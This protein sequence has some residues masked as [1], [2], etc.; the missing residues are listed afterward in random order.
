MKVKLLVFLSSLVLANSLQAQ[1]QDGGFAAG[2][3][4]GTTGLGI[5]AATRLSQSF[6][7]RGSYNFLEYE[8]DFDE[9]DINYDA[10]FNRN[11]LGFLVDWHPGSSNF[12]LSGGL[13]AHSDNNVSVLAEPGAGGTFRI[14]GNTYNVADIGSLSGEVSFDKQT[15]YLGIGW[16]RPAAV[17][18]WA[19]LADVG[20]QLQG[21]PQAELQSQTCT[22]P[23]ALCTRFRHDVEA[24]LQELEKEGEDFELWPVLNFSLIYSF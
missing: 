16:G 23:A 11:S 2:F 18:G 12:R 14:N 21:S 7:L 15:P 10:D 8:T 22:L 17:Q 24:E 13:F 3:R 9:S 5:E 4:F 1:Q 19:L 20:I 6:D